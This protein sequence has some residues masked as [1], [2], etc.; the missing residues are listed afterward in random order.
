MRT[1]RILPLRLLAPIITTAMLL[2]ATV[3]PARAQGELPLNLDNGSLVITSTGYSQAGAGEIP[4]VGGYILSGSASNTNTI[5]V[6]SGTHDITLSGAAVVIPP[7]SAT[8]LTAASTVCA[9]SITG[10]ADVTLI[11]QGDNVLTSAAG[12]AGLYVAAGAKLTVDGNGSLAVTGGAGRPSSSG[13]PRYGGG[14]GI[15]GNGYE[16]SSSFGAVVIKS[17]TVTATGGVTSMNANYG[18]GAGIGGG[19]LTGG[20]GTG[21]TSYSFPAGEISIY[22]GEINAYGGA[23]VNSSDTCGGAGVG[24][25]GIG[26]Q[27]EPFLSYIRIAIH[28][29]RTTA[30]GKNDGAGIGGGAN[31][32]SGTILVDSGI[33]TAYGGDEGD[34]ST[35][36]G[37]GIGAGDMAWASGISIGGNAS[38]FAQGGGAAAGIGGGNY[39][40]VWDLDTDTVGTI[41]I[42]G[43][44]AV[45][46]FGGSSG[47]SRG[48]AGIGAGRNYGSDHC[49]S[50]VITIK[51][52][53]V[54]TAY[55][56]INAQ[57]IGVGS[58]YN[59]ST[60]V[61]GEDV[62]AIDKT[63]SLKAFNRDTA[64]AAYTPDVQGGG[65]PSLVAFTL[66]ESALGGVFPSAGVTT[67]TTS[68]DNYM[69]LYSGTTGS[70]LLTLSDSSG[71]IAATPSVHAAFGNWAV[72]LASLQP[73]PLPYT[74]TVQAETG[75]GVDT[76]VNGSYAAGDVVTIAAAADANYSFSGWTSDNGGTF[77]DASSAVTTFTMPAADVTV[78]AK[79]T[80]VAVKTPQSK[81]PPGTS[82]FTGPTEP[83][84]PIKPTEPTKPAQPAPTTPTEQA[85]PDTGNNHDSMLC[86]VVLCVLF[87]MT[88]LLILDKRRNK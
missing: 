27:W 11:L 76:S 42:F 40:G 38:V 77:A 10:N 81:G 53:A 54:V 23:C 7:T 85:N 46:A 37:A 6:T 35:W 69:W 67:D 73:Q 51:D 39:G 88:G 72:L 30:T 87:T 29:G 17:G 25:G 13:T 84:E 26:D 50:G 3:L 5:Q 15:G 20:Q 49:N 33:V 64:Q 63:I 32:V 12:Y 82:R 52:K 68:S 43:D 80:S 75:G 65:A 44:A 61:S 78:T 18:A 60:A 71:P 14:A 8:S 48:G 45:I 24:S 56:G 36:G 34:G 2:S 21:G 55:A 57:A 58:G 66:A 22:G 19:G 9:F 1:G 47:T 31:C 70:Y 79:F 86:M 74:L 28:G 62:L 83:M 59:Y 4:Y 16:D 41:T